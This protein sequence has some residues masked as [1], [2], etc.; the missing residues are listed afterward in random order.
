MASEAQKN[1][2]WDNA[3]K[4]QGK[5]PALYRQDPY[6]NTMYRH[7]YGRASDM[8]W[9]VDH[10]KPKS[11]GGSDATVNLQALSTGINRSKQDSLVKKSRHSK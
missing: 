7:S 3:K 6:G 1:K 9:E 8:G 5:D 11:Q 4:T 10:I 2:A